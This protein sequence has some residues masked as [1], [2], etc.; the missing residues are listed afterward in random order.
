MVARRALPERHVPSYLGRILNGR[1]QPVGTC[2]QIAPTLLI[3]AWHVLSS[4]DLADVGANIVIDPLGGGRSF[5]GTVAVVDPEYDL[6]VIVSTAPLRASV[7]LV[8]RFGDA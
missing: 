2:F 5:N 4:I 7:R 1:A 3:T 8:S 6:A